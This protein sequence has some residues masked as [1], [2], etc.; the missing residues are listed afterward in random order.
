MSVVSGKVVFCEGQTGSLDYRLLDILLDGIPEP[1]TIVPCGSKFGFPNFA[2]GYFSGNTNVPWIAFRDRDFDKE[3]PT[4]PALLQLNS[5]KVFLSHRTTI[6][7]YLLDAVLIHRYWTEKFLQSTKIPSSRWAWGDSPGEAA[8]REEIE[9]AAREISDYQAVRWALGHLTNVGGARKQLATTWT[10]NSGNLPQSLK[11]EAC[12]K[13]AVELIRRFREAVDQ[14][15]EDIFDQRLTEYLIR[16]RQESF[17]SEKKYLIWFQGKDIQKAINQ[18]NNHF[19]Q[20]E[21]FFDWALSP[22]EARI[23]IGAY[24]D[25]MEFRNELLRLS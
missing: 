21:A 10:K 16:F 3:P 7:N 15:S 1:P 19:L 17:W 11:L 2:S 13:E 12:R 6:E 5:R 14:V 22:S 9:T 24:P 25:L 20:W 4:E 23:D 8:I 18:R